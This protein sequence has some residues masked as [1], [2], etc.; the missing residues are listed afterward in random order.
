MTNVFLPICLFYT[1]VFQ[2]ASHLGSLHRCR[3]RSLAQ[4]LLGSPAPHLPCSQVSSRLSNQLISRRVYLLRSQ[5]ISQ[6]CSHRS[7]HLR[8]LLNSRLVSPAC[9]LL[10]FQVANLQNSRHGSRHVYLVRS[11][12]LDQHH[13]PLFNPLISLL[14]NPP[15]SLLSNHLHSPLKLPQSVPLGSRVINRLNSLQSNPPEY[16]RTSLPLSR[17]RSQLTS[18][19]VSQQDNPPCSQA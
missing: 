16:L 12:R 13:S 10:Y 4:F 6:L 14:L 5:V 18:P 1:S 8:S 17:Q 9:S 15:P 3:Q 19:L 11:H 7:D 2:R